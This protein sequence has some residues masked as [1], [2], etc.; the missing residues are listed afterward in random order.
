MTSFGNIDVDTVK[1]DIGISCLLGSEEF[2]YICLTT[3]IKSAK[4]PERLVFHLGVDTGKLA[5][6]SIKPEVLKKINELS[7]KNNNNNI[8]ID[9]V[10]TGYNRSSLS[11]GTII[12][13]LY[14]KFT[15]PFGI[16][17][18]ND[19]VIYQMHWD[20]V[21]IK[22]MVD[23]QSVIFGIP[24][25]PI[26]NKDKYQNFPCAT[27]C[28]LY[29][30]LTWSLNIDFKPHNCTKD[31]T[32]EAGVMYDRKICAL[33]KVKVGSKIKL[34]T[35]SD[36][37]LKIKGANLHSSILKPKKNNYYYNNNLAL[38]HFCKG[39][40]KNIN[41]LKLKMW[42]ITIITHFKRHNINISYIM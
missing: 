3:M 6:Q 28:I 39:S 26:V 33:F 40:G 5:D 7:S 29:R 20:S 37:Y 8:H 32:I 24:Y 36:L 16:I 1:I 25:D 12:N 13:H 34:D 17:S 18:D 31:T 9:Y 11:H 14:K 4:N 22:H 35:G 19:L 2:A 23:T 30:P 38:T 15:H 10:Q 42:K 27:F 21:F 41:P